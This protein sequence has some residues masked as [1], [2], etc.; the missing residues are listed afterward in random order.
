MS[1][2]RKRKVKVRRRRKLAP[3][4]LPLRWREMLWHKAGWIEAGRMERRHYERSVHLLFALWQLDGGE[5]A[6][7]LRVLRNCLP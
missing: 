7:A 1:K 3:W 2:R 6:L 5:A 4:E